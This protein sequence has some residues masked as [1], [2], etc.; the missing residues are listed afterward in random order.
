MKKGW[1]WAILLVAMLVI[2][3]CRPAEDDVDRDASET[4]AAEDLGACQ[5]E[6]EACVDES[7]LSA[8]PEEETAPA[9]EPEP[10]ETV[11]ETPAEEPVATDAEVLESTPLVDNPFLVRETDWVMGPDDA[12]ITMIEY[13]DFQ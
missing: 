6:D 3:A 11:E 13:G 2:S 7:V 5:P 12:F 9:G 8:T 1:I 10:E 4:A